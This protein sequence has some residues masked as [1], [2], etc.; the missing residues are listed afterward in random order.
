MQLIA[1]PSGS[2]N[3]FQ[4]DEEIVEIGEIEEIEEIVGKWWCQAGN[5]IYIYRCIHGITCI[6]VNILHMLRERN[7]V[8]M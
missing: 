4:M 7:Y 8:C 5:E 6:D 1:H 2:R 3:P